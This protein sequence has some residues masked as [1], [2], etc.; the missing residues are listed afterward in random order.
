MS[1]SVSLPVYIRVGDSE[2][3]RVGTIEA[4]SAEEAQAAMADL[5]RAAAAAIDKVQP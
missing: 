3:S 2:E 1:K 4:D 5:L